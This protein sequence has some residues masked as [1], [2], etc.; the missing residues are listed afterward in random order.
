M[1]SVIWRYLEG[2]SAIRESEPST[3]PSGGIPPGQSVRALKGHGVFAAF[4]RSPALEAALDAIFGTAAWQRTKR[5]ARIL[6]T[7][8]GPEPWVMPS[9]WHFDASFD[10]A[11]FPVPWV[12]LWAFM[13]EVAPCGGGTLV[14]EGSHRLV[15]RY[16]QDLPSEHRP[17]NGVNFARFMKQ[18]PFLKRLAG[19]GSAE[20]AQREV[21]RMTADIAGI[22][23]RARELTGHPG[24]LFITH[25]Q[26]L[27][28]AAPNTSGNVRLMLTGSIG[29]L[30]GS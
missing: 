8:P 7:F 14:L 24:D 13:G 5:M 18:D 3:W 23:V 1:R 4:S 30:A 10:T 11:A 20:E 2:R 17:G 26:L 15:E 9:G 22:E 21:L 12:Q 16:S 27:H 29:P 19:G 28:C 6:L 25:G